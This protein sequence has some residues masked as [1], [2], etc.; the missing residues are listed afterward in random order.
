MGGKRRRD[1][2]IGESTCLTSVSK[3]GGGGY[4]LSGS[5]AIQNEDAIHS[6]TIITYFCEVLNAVGVLEQCCC[7]LR[8]H[9]KCYPNRHRLMRLILQ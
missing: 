4:G 5:P 7:R 9:R 3:S 1:G 2:D 8:N 6:Y